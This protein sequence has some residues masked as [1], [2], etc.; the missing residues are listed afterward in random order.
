MSTA[1]TRTAA[2]TAK[3]AKYPGWNLDLRWTDYQGT[4]PHYPMGIH[5]NYLGADSAMIPVREGAMMLVMDRLTDKLN[6]HIKVFD[7]EIVIKWKAE[8]LAW[9]DEDLWGRLNNCDQ[10]DDVRIPTPI[11]DKECVDYVSDV[12]PSRR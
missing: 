2:A 8:A 1:V 4:D 10:D 9:P 11:L 3:L 12:L 6:W 5:H 7:D